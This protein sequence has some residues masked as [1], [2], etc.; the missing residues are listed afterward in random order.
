MK[1]GKKNP[2]LNVTV[3]YALTLHPSRFYG[4]KENTFVFGIGFS[5]NVFGET[6]HLIR[7]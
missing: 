4:K 2:K 6:Y 7:H 1:R 5:R 3:S